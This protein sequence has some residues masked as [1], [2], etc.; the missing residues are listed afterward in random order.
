MAPLILEIMYISAGI[1]LMMLGIF[2]FIKSKCFISSGFWFIFG[3]IFTFGKILPHR[4]VGGLLV[5]LAVLTATKKIKKVKFDT[6]SAEQKQEY[7]LAVGSKI[8]IPA[9]SIGII[10][11]LIAKF[12]GLGGLVGLG[13][14]SISSLIIALFVTKSHPKYIPNDT[15]SLLQQMGPVLILP[16]LLSALG[17]IFVKVDLGSFITESMSSLI[18]E[19]S[20][21]LGVLI[22]C[23]S[24]AL[25]TIIMGN[26]F[27][28][29][30]FVTAGIGFPFV[31]SAGGN[32]VIVSALGLT[33]GYCGTL[34]TPMAANFNI[35]PTT[36]LEMNNK[37]LVILTQLP[38][39][40]TMLILHI[41]LMY[42]WAF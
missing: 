35:L 23:T 19:N 14:A 34:M 13:I 28:A 22:Y 27:A 40:L 16:Q 36:V 38:V 42:F 39:A 20:R 5:L 12:T 10:T 21:F 24:M 4:L 17:S 1:I 7:S 6:P 30:A 15:F 41:T 29:F 33:S 26:A 37:S 11:F 25:F 31:I 3:V 32:P 2:T 9:V 8:F 18:P